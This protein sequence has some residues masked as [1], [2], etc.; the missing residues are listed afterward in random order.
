MNEEAKSIETQKKITKIV[1]GLYK[2]MYLDDALNVVLKEL[3][4]LKRVENKFNKLKGKA[5]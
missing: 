3:Q 2:G 4:R 1:P 5:K